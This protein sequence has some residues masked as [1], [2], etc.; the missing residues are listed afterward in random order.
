MSTFIRLFDFRYNS[1]HPSLNFLNFFQAVSFNPQAFDW[2]DRLRT[3]RWVDGAVDLQGAGSK[4]EEEPPISAQRLG[5]RPAKKKVIETEP[6]P[7]FVALDES[8]KDLQL[9][10]STVCN[11]AKFKCKTEV[12]RFKDTLMFQSRLFRLVL[13]VL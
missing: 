4:A 12:I 9:L 5:R 8:A 6:E 13:P 1:C 3:V 11:Y 7:P 2:D 10:I